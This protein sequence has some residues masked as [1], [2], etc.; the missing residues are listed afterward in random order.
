MENAPANAVLS[1]SQTLVTSM[2]ATNAGLIIG[3]AAYMSPEQAP[4]D[5]KPTRAAICS[6]SG[7]S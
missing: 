7:V 5:G 2:A 4:A 3:T 6:R 1:N